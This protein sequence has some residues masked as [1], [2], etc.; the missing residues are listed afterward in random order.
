MDGQYSIFDYHP[1]KKKPYEYSFKRYVGQ[2]VRASFSCKDNTP[3][4]IYTVKS[5]EPYYT[6]IVDDRGKEYAGTNCTIAP[7]N[8][9]EWEKT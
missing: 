5:I 4:K 7:V 6:I 8:D 1:E 9:E 2:K 3:G